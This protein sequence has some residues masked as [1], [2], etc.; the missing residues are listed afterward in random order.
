MERVGKCCWEISCKFILIFI[1]KPTFPRKPVWHRRLLGEGRITNLRKE[2]EMVNY[3]AQGE[4][5]VCI[6]TLE[7][8]HQRALLMELMEHLFTTGGCQGLWLC[9]HSFN[10]PF[11]LIC[12]P[13][14]SRWANGGI[15][16][17]YSVNK[18]VSDGSEIWTHLGWLK[19]PM[20]IHFLRFCS[21]LWHQQWGVTPLWRNFLILFWICTS[22]KTK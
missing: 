19:T 20:L 17:L 10:F 6:H 18:L 11:N 4:G 15:G 1:A 7:C 16:N 3:W 2:N 13:H 21:G 9:I 8:R 14:L 22:S 5:C 12:Y